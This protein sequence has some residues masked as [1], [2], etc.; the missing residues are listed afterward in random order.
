MGLVDSEAKGLSKLIIQGLLFRAMANTN[1]YLQDI[2]PT[3][4]SL[5]YD[6]TTNTATIISTDSKSDVQIQDICYHFAVSDNSLTLSHQTTVQDSELQTMAL[7]SL[8][9]FSRSASNLSLFRLPSFLACPYCGFL[10]TN[11]TAKQHTERCMLLC[12]GII[13][14]SDSLPTETLTAVS[15]MFQLFHRS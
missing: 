2:N 4:I 3:S 13:H 5:R 1:E 7:P 12:D 15:L 6:T 9:Y 11:E 8:R 10:L 14:V